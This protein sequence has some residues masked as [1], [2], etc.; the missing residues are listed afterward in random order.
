[1]ILQAGKI[2]LPQGFIHS[3]GNGVAQ[4]QTACL[5][6]HGKADA[7]LPVCFQKILGKPLGLL[8]KEQVAAVVKCSLGIAAGSFGG[9]APKFLY[10]IFLKKVFQIIIYSYIHK[11]PVI[12]TC[13]AN[14][15]FGNVKA[16]RA[17][18]MEH[19]AGGCAGTGDVAA[20]LRDL[21]FVEHDIQHGIHL[22][23]PVFWKRPVIVVQ[24]FP[25]IK[26]KIRNFSTFLFY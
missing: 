8:A 13:P 4:I 2:Q 26:A 23:L 6:P 5:L 1:M 14:G 22:K 20:I 21:R 7:A 25:K 3:N 12:Q 16:Q 10:I 11:M 15:F 24:N 19:R 17:D 18:Q 9:K